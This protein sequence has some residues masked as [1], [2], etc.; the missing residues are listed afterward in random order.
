MPPLLSI[1][2]EGKVGVL[3]PSKHDQSQVGAR[4]RRPSRA[5]PISLERAPG[6]QL[7]LRLREPGSLPILVHHL[8]DQALFMIHLPLL[9]KIGSLEPKVFQ[10]LERAL[11]ARSPR[12]DLWI[13]QMGWFNER[14]DFHEP[15]PFLRLR[16]Q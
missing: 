16:K 5:R 9:L 1:P 4:E 2:S 11:I 14:M 8:G 7:P 13:I 15:P 10:E 12:D 6:E 3:C